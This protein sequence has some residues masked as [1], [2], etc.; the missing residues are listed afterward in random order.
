VEVH[1]LNQCKTISALFSYINGQMTVL[2]IILFKIWSSQASVD[3]TVILIN[4]L[5][6]EFVP[7]PVVR[8]FS[9]PL[10]VAGTGSVI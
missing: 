3:K 8:M 5:V 10:A 7:L 2:F 6:T 9:G 1:L 4:N